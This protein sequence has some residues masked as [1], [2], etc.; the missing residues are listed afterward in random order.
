MKNPSSL[1]FRFHNETAIIQWDVIIFTAKLKPWKY[2]KARGGGA[3][4]PQ[5]GWITE[6]KK[7]ITGKLPATVEEPVKFFFW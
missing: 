1:A 3:L 4:I 2:I 7:R 5:T 6:K